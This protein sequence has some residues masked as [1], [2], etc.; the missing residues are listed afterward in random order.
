MANCNDV[1]QH[2]SRTSHVTHQVSDILVPVECRD[3]TS[4]PLAGRSLRC[5][6]GRNEDEAAADSNGA[7]KSALVMAPLWALTGRS[8]AR[9]EVS[10]NNVP[11][12]L[13]QAKLGLSA[14]LLI[15]TAP[16][17]S[18]LVMAPLWALRCAFRGRFSCPTWVTNI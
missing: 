6:T 9:S 5:V 2:I 15:S 11:V 8:D 12:G 10:S 16:A 1:L 13:P 18:A 14:P 4:Y 17:K 7:G 3:A